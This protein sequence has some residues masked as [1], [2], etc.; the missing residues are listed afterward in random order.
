VFSIYYML[1][2]SIAKIMFFLVTFYSG[3]RPIGKS[4][5]AFISLRARFLDKEKFNTR[6][7]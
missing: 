3:L 4:S 2:K 7:S 5:I 1:F 6:I